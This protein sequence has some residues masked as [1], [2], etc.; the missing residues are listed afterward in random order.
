MSAPLIHIGTIHAGSDGAERLVVGF[1]GDRI[2]YRRRHRGWENGG[3][4]LA[5]EWNPRNLKVHR[6]VFERYFTRQA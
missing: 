6:A 4:K 1:D 5:Q 2:I 3:R